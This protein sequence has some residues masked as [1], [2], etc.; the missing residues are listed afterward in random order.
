MST[1]REATAPGRCQGCDLLAAALPWDFPVVRGAPDRWDLIAGMLRNAE[2]RGF[3]PDDVVVVVGNPEL[4][5][6]ELRGRGDLTMMTAE[7]TKLPGRY[8]EPLASTFAPLAR[9]APP[10]HVWVVASIGTHARGAV[11]VFFHRAP[12]AP[13]AA[14]VRVLDLALVPEDGG[15]APGAGVTSPGG[16]A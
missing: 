8:P 6:A 13:S 1:V 10:G 4:L 12:P 16:S 14:A 11:V 5:P 9:P 15:P 2:E 7:R 3:T